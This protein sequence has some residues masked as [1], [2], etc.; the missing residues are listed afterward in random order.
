ML[1]CLEDPDIGRYISDRASGITTVREL[2]RRFAYFLRTNLALHNNWAFGL[3]KDLALKERREKFQQKNW[4]EVLIAI[5]T[6][7]G[8]GSDDWADNFVI[9]C[10]ATFLCKEIWQVSSTS[11]PRNPWGQVGGMFADWHEPA[12]GPVI[13][14]GYLPQ[15]HFEAVRHISSTENASDCMVCNKSF[16]TSLFQHLKTFSPGCQK[17]YNMERLEQEDSIK[18]QR[19]KKQQLSEVERK[20]QEEKDNERRRTQKQEMSEDENKNNQ[21][22]DQDRERKQ[23]QQMSD[24]KKKDFLKKQR[25]ERQQLSKEKK[26]EQQDKDKERKRKRRQQMSDKKKKD[27]LKKRREERQSLSEEKKKDLLKKRREERQQ[28]SVEKKKEQEDKDKERKSNQ[29][30][31]MSDEE[32]KDLLK[33]RREE[34]QS[35]SEEKKKDLLKK[36]R[37]DRQQLSKEKKKEQEVKDKKR[38][39]KQKQTMSKEA[40][41]EIKRIRR[42]KNRAKFNQMSKKEKKEFYRKDYERQKDAKTKET[43]ED[44]YR[45]MCKDLKDTWSVACICCHKKISSTKTKKYSDDTM[46]GGEINK[47]FNKLMNEL[48]EGLKSCIQTPDDTLF[49]EQLRKMIEITKEIHLCST[50]DRTLRQKKKMPAQCAKNGLQIDKLPVEAQDELLKNLNDLEKVLISKNILFIKIFQMP[51]TRWQK[52]IDKCVN[53]PLFCNDLLKTLNKLCPLPRNPEDSGLIEVQLKRKLEYKNI[54]L[55][56]YVNRD[57]L[58]EAVRILK[59]SGHPGYQDVEINDRFGIGDDEE[60]D[61]EI[62]SKSD[63]SS[64]K[65]METNS[66]N[67]EEG[68]A[69]ESDEEETEQAEDSIRKNQFDLAGQTLMTDRYPE[70]SVETELKKVVAGSENSK[71]KPVSI[72]PGEGKIPTDLMRD[73]DFLINAFP[74][75]FPTGKYG[76]NEERDV[77]LSMQK[78]FTQ[79]L[80]NVNPQFAKDIAFVFTALYCI[81]RAT[82]ERSINISYQRGKVVNGTLE[83]FDNICSIF[84]DTPGSFR[85]WQK[86]RFEILAKLEQLGAFQFFFTLSCADKRWDENFVTILRQDGF[87]IEH[88]KEPKKGCTGDDYSYEAYKIFVKKDGVRVPLDEFLKKGKYDKHEMVRKNVLEVTMNFDKRVQSFMKNILMAESSPMHTQFYH[89]RVEFQL[90]GAGHIHGV[91]WIDLAKLEEKNPELKGLKDIMA[92]LRTSSRLDDVERETT[93]KFVDKFVTCSLEDYGELSDTVRDVQTHRHSGNRKKKTGCYK[94]G[95]VCRFG[96]PR[97]PSDRT[98]IAQPLERK[99]G[100]SAKE[101]E[102]KKKRMKELLD[103]VKHILE[104][105]DKERLESITLKEI[106]EKAGIQS[107]EY[108]DALGVSQKGACVILKRKPREIYINNYNPEWL[109]AWNG[110]MDLAVCLDFFAVITYITDYYTKSESEM[111]AK[112]MAAAKACK[113]KARGDQMRFMAQSFLT[114][115]ETGES[116]AFYRIFPHLHLS[117][118]NLKCVFVHT[119]FPRNRSQ[120]ARKVKDKEEGGEDEGDNGNEENEHSG[121]DIITVPG[122]EGKFKRTVSHQQKYAARPQGLSNMSFA[123]FVSHYD[124]VPATV[125]KKEEFDNDGCTQHICSCLKECTCKKIIHWEDE[126]EQYL[127]DY[128][129]LNENIGHMKLRKDPSILRYHKIDEGKNPHEYAYSLLQLF[130]P[131]RN[132]K[133]LPENDYEECLEMLER[134]SES[135]TRLQQKLFPLRKAVEE[136]RA[137]LE[138][139][140]DPRPTHIGDQLDPEKEQENEDAAMEGLVEDEEFAGRHPGEKCGDEE[141]GITPNRGIFRRVDIPKDEKGLLEMN[142]LVREL[143]GEQRQVQDIMTEFSKCTRTSSNSDMSK[144]DPPLLKIHGG[145]GCGKSHLIKVITLVCEYWLSYGNK[146]PDK[147]SVIK[148]APTGRAANIIDGRTLHSGL[149][150]GFGNKY[151]SLPDELRASMQDELSDLKVVIIDE[152]S[153]VKSDIIYQLHL[154]LQEIKRS[155]Q[156]FGGVSVLLVGDLLQLRPVMAEWIFDPPEDANFRVSHAIRPLWDLFTPFELTHNHRQGKDKEY[157]DLLNKL[158]LLPPLTKEEKKEMNKLTEEERTKMDKRLSE[159][160]KKLLASRVTPERPENALYVFGWNNQVNA[161]NEMKLEELEGEVEVMEAI[162]RNTYQKN[163]TPK[164]GTDGNINKIPFKQTLRLKKGAKA[165]ITFNVDTP[166]GLTNGTTGVVAGFEKH[167]GKVVSVLI[168]LDDSRY[169]KALRLKQARKCECLGAKGAVPIARVCFEYSLGKL[170]KEHSA[171]AKCIQFPLTLAWAVTCHKCQGWTIEAPTLLVADLTSCWG[172]AMAYVMLG[173]I[174]NINQLYLP[175]LDTTKIYASEK[176]LT[177]AQKMKT[178]ALNNAANIVNDK[179]TGAILDSLRITSLNIQHLVN[180]LEDL[181]VDPTILLSDIICL[182]ETFLDRRPIP[183]IPGY[184]FFSA[185]RGR[186]KGVAIF[187]RNHMLKYLIKV[188]EIDKSFAQCLKLSFP[189]F[190]VITVYR[191]QICNKPH[192]NNQFLQMLVTFIDRGYIL[193]GGKGK[194]TIVTGDFNFEFWTSPRSPLAMSIEQLG[195]SQIVKTPTTVHGK[196]IDHIYVP[197]DETE[198]EYKVY[199]PY[200]A[201]HEAILVILQGWKTKYTRSKIRKIL[202]RKKGICVENMCRIMP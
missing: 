183:K 133:D 124:L 13:T 191:N 136:G 141:G 151:T 198:V 186:G 101:F 118:S 42:E 93:A 145:A 112:M 158:R 33:K 15:L 108:H 47:V 72:A 63:E 173:R 95:S 135:L 30:Q 119:G 140:P 125:V 32:K 201:N 128:I 120:F 51:K 87:V 54:V 146:H 37:E 110:N 91:L 188:E 61:E 27:L 71:S 169:G 98:I 59:E 122:R 175:S 85:Y 192:I 193:T 58:L 150:I 41:D 17:F 107:S 60:E 126:H 50:C 138:N 49:P 82:L 6:Y 129:K 24:N 100:E 103:K 53:V 109:K 35:L 104:E 178:Q 190:D 142:K 155:K 127:P 180:H 154:R 176:A 56:R 52:T 7:V 159:E 114:H 194:R 8:D 40:R 134:L 144:P 12:V 116:E 153:M 111:M 174:Q 75:L 43:A 137:T 3:A 68:E 105:M 97:F 177:E 189:T 92:K 21:E 10:M 199:R 73:K 88:E 38:K 83:N 184:E 66:S 139:F 55:K 46:E 130:M 113:D 166:D 143:D 80:Q 90:R 14:I 26:K 200:Y 197:V 106:L 179:W 25:E 31:Q 89:Y 171:K 163:F 81:E 156:D 70:T 16:K 117:E 19:E 9:Q 172:P 1:A 187:L 2:R 185:G 195:L 121:T 11:D 77:V 64:Y 34:R 96:Y 4:E 182:Q 202:K 99:D 79:R 18:K 157:G 160:D 48:E 84:D 148:L 39:R 115:R 196:C 57:H 69:K 168:Q 22:K 123:Q 102:E 76:L 62:E 5:E 44:R 149:R 132:E 170:E 78:Y 131:W 74:H 29:R 36:R 181:K 86:R 67:H 28:L 20:E 165:M 167:N 94:K 45:N 65:S 162:N 161:H 147:P 23:K 152:M 164:V